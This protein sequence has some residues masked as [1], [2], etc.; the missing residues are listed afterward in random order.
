M[1][2][3]GLVKLALV[4]LAGLMVN[5]GKAQT[6][7]ASAQ[8][9]TGGWGS[10]TNSNIGIH[11]DT[12]APNIAGFAPNTPLWYQWT[13]SVSGEVELDTVGSVLY[14]TTSPLDTVLGVFTGTSL[15]A[16]PSN[17]R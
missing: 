1:R 14:G 13:P 2:N 12:H 3:T 16:R 15:Y 4:V 9:L 11:R 8:V 17:W 10:V 7:F 6:N 5:V